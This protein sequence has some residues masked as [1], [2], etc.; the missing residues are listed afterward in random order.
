ME[1]DRS[2]LALVLGATGGVGGATAEALIA[3]GWQVRA[4]VRDR[5]AATAGWSGRIGSP[6]W[7]L[8]D[9]MVREDVVRAAEGVQVIVHAVNPPGYRNWD[10]LVLPMIENSIAAAAASGA[11]IVL[12]G[13][14]YNFDP[15]TSPLI[16]E[17]TPQFPKT[18]KGKI[19]VALE[20]RL[21]T[22]AADLGVP[23]LI[24]RAGDFL[25]PKVR[26][27]WFAQ[28]MVRPGQPVR[29]LINPGRIGTG[30]SWAY[31]PDLAETIA[32][33]LDDCDR[34]RKFE[35]LQ[36]QGYWDPDG[37]QMIET[38]TQ[39]SKRHSLP[40][41]GFPWWLLRIASPFSEVM[42]EMLE[43]RDFWQRPVRLDN[44]RLVE[45][46]GTEPHTLIDTAVT[47][48][49]A[50]LG[51]ID[52]GETDDARPS[53]NLSSLANNPAPAKTR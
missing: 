39:A 25:G 38:I 40:V 34:L 28:A 36:F 46:L 33:L 48:T 43:I 5:A 1:T 47:Q 35:R 9:A 15:D 18:R 32:R 31:L 41:W 27:S 30:H 8:G 3:H 26:A 44:R 50:G 42:R 7:R 52:A 45:L 11:R 20:Q 19:R 29:R 16:T 37:R 24:V 17:T 10:K 13:T 23:S 21:E 22:A 53:P 14:L 6:E 12:P 49:L 51:C 4:L 2:K